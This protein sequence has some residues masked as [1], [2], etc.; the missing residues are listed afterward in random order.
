MMMRRILAMIVIALLVFASPLGAAVPD[1]F[2]LQGFLTDAAGAPIDGQVSMTIDLYDA[3]TGGLLIASVGPL[4]VDVSEGVYEVSTGFTAMHFQG[5]VR[6][7]EITVDSETLAPRTQVGST[8]FT[9]ES[10]SG[11]GGATGATG[12]TGADGNDG[13][14]GA[15]GAIGPTGPTGADGNDG[16]AGAAG[17]IGPTGPT[18]AD[19]NDGAAGAAGAI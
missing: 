4:M 15:A 1:V 9:F 14:A 13:A 17:A 18:G 11:A 10:A 6:F 2:K 19:G 16:A 12:P 3:Q 7:L 8:A 5:S